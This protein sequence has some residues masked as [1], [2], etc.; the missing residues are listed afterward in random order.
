VVGMA[1]RED[2]PPSGAI[3]VLVHRLPAVR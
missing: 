1:D 2:G 3:A